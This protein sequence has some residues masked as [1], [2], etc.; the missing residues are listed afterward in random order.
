MTLN[1]DIEITGLTCPDFFARHGFGGVLLDTVARL[2]P[3]LEHGAH[4]WRYF[5]NT[6]LAHNLNNAASLGYPPGTDI[7]DEA[8]YLLNFDYQD[9]ILLV[10]ITT[11]SVHMTLELKRFRLPDFGGNAQNASVRYTMPNVAIRSRLTI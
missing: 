9:S 5:H 3:S 8:N 4:A 11:I 7:E 10:A 1:R 2:Q 6:R